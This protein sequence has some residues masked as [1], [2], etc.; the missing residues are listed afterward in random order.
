MWIFGGQAGT[1]QWTPW[2][3]SALPVDI[4][5]LEHSLWAPLDHS[6]TVHS[7]DLEH[8]VSDIV[9]IYN[10]SPHYNNIMTVMSTDNVMNYA[11]W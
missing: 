1:S 9:T 7:R 2:C 11:R 6:V 3:S 5:D 4:W 10:V 8:F